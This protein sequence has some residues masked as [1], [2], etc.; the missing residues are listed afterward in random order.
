LSPSISTI[1]NQQLRRN[2]YRKWPWLTHERCL[3]Q[4]QLRR[5]INIALRRL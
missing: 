4:G 3:R 1:L 2:S 5:N